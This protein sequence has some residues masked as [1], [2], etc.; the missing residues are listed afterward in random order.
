MPGPI[1]D[2]Y[3]PE[4]GTGLNADEVERAVRQLHRRLGEVLGGQPP[5]YIVGVVQGD[6]GPAITAT[7]TEREWRILRFACERASESL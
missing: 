3:D 6:S 4:F 5:R 1:S 7:L 2:S